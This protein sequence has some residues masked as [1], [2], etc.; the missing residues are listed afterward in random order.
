MNDPRENMRRAKAVR[1]PP[2]A[3]AR[4]HRRPPVRAALALDRRLTIDEATRR[5]QHGGGGGG[6]GLEQPYYVYVID[7]DTRLVGVVSMRDLILTSADATLD[8]VMRRD[9]VFARTGADEDELARL[10]RRHRLP[11]LPV[12]DDGGR[13]LGV[14]TAS[15]VLAAIEERDTESVQRMV[16]AGPGERLTSPWHFSFRK[17]LPWLCASLVLAGGGASV[18]RLFDAAISAWAILAAFMP[19]V[20]GM[21]G[22]AS[23]Q[24]MAV[25][26]RGIATGDA[27]R[28]S[29]PRVVAREL[30]IGAA[31]GVV[32]GL[33]GGI[34]AASAAFLSGGGNAAVLGALVGASLLT[35]L[36]VGCVW[37]ACTPFIM[38]RLG[39]DPA[40]S[41]TIFTTTLTDLV[42]FATLL[43]LATL[44]L[45]A[46]VV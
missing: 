20:A 46:F 39:F 36:V 37:G 42:G 18:V 1:N 43:G 2:P 31:S 13:L 17:R 6:G 19:V 22:N 21:G 12:I 30:R 4:E 23:A 32:T 45:A 27:R 44:I 28:G 41:A 25:A 7:A 14:V 5:L 40:Q 3:D 16:G 15:D 11:V 29:L 9:V 33:V 26:I 38:M 35:N 34:V 10:L 24:A 8:R